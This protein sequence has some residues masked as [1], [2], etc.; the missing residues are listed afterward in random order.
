MV[1][2]K[3]PDATSSDYDAMLPFWKMVGTILDGAPAMRAA[4]QAYLP[5]FPN[6]TD[7]DYAYRAK[8]A[9]FTNIYRDIAENLAAKPFAKELALAEGAPSDIEALAEDIDGQGNNLHVFAENVFFNGINAAIDWIFVD[10]TPV[11][12]GATRAEE[13]ALGA[14]PYW[15]HIPAN[16]VLAVYSATIDGREQIVHARIHEPDVKRE[17]YDE[18]AVNRVRVLNREQ[19][20]DGGYADATWE[21]FEEQKDRDGK[22]E[23]VSVGN[24]KIAIGVIA[25]VP[26]VTGRRKGSSWRFVPPMQDA[27]YLQ[28]EHYQQET[29]LKSIKEQACFPMLAG[30]GVTPATDESGNAVMVPVG[31]KSVLFAPMNGDGNHGT[32]AFIEPSSA[33]LKFLAEDVLATEK[34]LRE[35]GRQPLV[36]RQITVI[37]SGMNA[38]KANSAIQAWALG[39]KDALE[40]ALKLTAQWMNVDSQPEVVIHTDFAIETET[41]K[42]PDVLIKMREMK[43]ISREALIAEAK[44]RDWLGPEYDADED[45]EKL[46]E[47][48]PGEDTPEDMAAALPPTPSDQIDDAGSPQS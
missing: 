7:T 35:I 29:N 30:N 27:A 19:L 28:I 22:S 23:W 32:W 39:L 6:E 18:V 9:K 33:S 4:G 3:K 14:R 21:V 38:Q 1:D 42:A 15:V 25:L 2:E 47:E 5:K 37:Q 13:R 12:E 26:F 20:P 41:D 44:R 8:N 43:D 45:M 40:Q 36:D 24:G 10:K 46:L 11:P 16:R 17:K 34:Q 31:P 48:E